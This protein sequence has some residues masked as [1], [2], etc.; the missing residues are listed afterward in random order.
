MA[1][2]FLTFVSAHPEL[3]RIVQEA[4]FV[5][6]EAYRA[7]FRTFAQ[8]YR[9]GLE[10]AAWEETISAGDAEIRAWALMG[11]AR[12]LGELQVV[13]NG[14]HSIDALVETAHDLIENGL[15]AGVPSGGGDRG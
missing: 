7:Y 2:P 13:F 5:D 1:S 8:G 10:K 6:P 15:R 11:V 12:A 9:E 14:G 3:Y 4:Q